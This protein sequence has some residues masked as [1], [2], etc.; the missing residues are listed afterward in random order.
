MK[1]HVAAVPC[2]LGLLL[3]F[4]SLSCIGIES[5]GVQQERLPIEVEERRLPAKPTYTCGGY[6][7]YPDFGFFVHFLS[8]TP[9]GTSL[10]FDHATKLGTSDATGRNHRTLT[11]VHHTSGSYVEPPL[12]GFHADM[13]PDGTRIVYSTCEFSTEPDVSRG[14]Y[15][16]QP[17]FHYEIAVINLDGTSKQRLTENTFLDHYPVWSPNGS[18][19][20]FISNP[21]S[22][23]IPMELETELFTMASDGT[24]IKRV[25]SMR[26]NVVLAPPAWS[27]D[28]QY[29]AFLTYDMKDSPP[30]KTLHTVRV[31]GSNLRMVAENVSSVPAWSPDGQKIA[32]AMVDGDDIALYILAADGSVA[33]PI[34]T[35]VNR[36]AIDHIEQPYRG[37]I[38]TVSWSPNGSYLLH[39]C[40]TPM[41]TVCIVTT[42]GVRVGDA[43]LNLV[44]SWG[45]RHVAAWSPDGSRFAVNGVSYFSFD[46]STNLRISLYTM[47]VDGTDVEIVLR[48]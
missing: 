26:S 2:I 30:R 19:I 9:D 10:I 27:P 22:L 34:V 1:V 39:S 31:D 38:H 48:K 33:R 41:M 35:I 20:A 11:T 47:A 28:G 40:F 42:E 21:D 45:G 7:S 36:E 3:A 5:D 18:R 25:T 37:W 43:P 24:D 17:E 15:P 12:Y 6:G 44:E 13:S 16:D 4:L 23:S 14:T 8:W 32:V 46:A 29:L